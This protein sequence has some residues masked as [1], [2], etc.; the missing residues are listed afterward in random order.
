MIDKLTTEDILAPVYFVAPYSKQQKGVIASWNDQVVHVH[1]QI[2]GTHQ[3]RAMF[4]P[5]AYEN[6]YFG[7]FEVLPCPECELRKPGACCARCNGVGAL[8]RRK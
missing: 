5:T 2:P 7:D 3:F 1:C 8:L 6:L 4:T